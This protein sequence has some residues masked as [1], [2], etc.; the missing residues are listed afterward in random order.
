MTLDVPSHDPRQRLQQLRVITAAYK[1][2]TPAEPILPSSNSPLQALLALRRTLTLVDQTKASVLET[3]ENIRKFQDQVRQ[4]EADLRDARSMTMALET[5]IERLRLKD[6]ESLDRSSEEL[7]KAM[8][9]EY[10]QQSKNFKTQ[11]RGL[12][13][14]FNKFVDEHLAIMLAA[15]ELGGPVVGDLIGLDEGMLKAGFNHQGKT[16]KAKSD[17]ASTNAKRKRRN[18]EVWGSKN[19]HE[20]AED[21][22][23]SE[24]QAAH[25]NFRSLTED[26][27]NAAAGDEDSGPYINIARESA[28]VRFLVRANVAQFHPSNARRLRLID[29]GS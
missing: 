14:S 23:R 15:E 12:V 11:L 16:K 25:A 8:M 24:K 7:A 29:F 4:D 17:N 3:H 2:L 26:L 28:A 1:S 27:L 20:E 18:D 19:E 6:I 5:R 21:G 10:Q 22:I 13:R 9:Q